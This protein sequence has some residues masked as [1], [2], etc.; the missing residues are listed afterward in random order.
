MKTVRMNLTT[1][2]VSNPKTVTLIMKSFSNKSHPLSNSN[3][4][5]VNNLKS[6][7][8]L[9]NTLKYQHKLIMNKLIKIL[10]T[11]KINTNKGSLKEIFMANLSSVLSITKN[12]HKFLIKSFNLN[13]T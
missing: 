2:T 4:L 3:N 11:I 6:L 9:T 1:Y 13:Q 10:S 12:N 7:R 8:K 5:Q